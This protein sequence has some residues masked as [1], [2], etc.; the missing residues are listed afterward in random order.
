MTRHE[1]TTSADVP[2]ARW[3]AMGADMRALLAVV[4]AG[5]ATVAGP[6][7]T[8]AP[9]IDAERLAFTVV[10]PGSGPVTVD[11]HRAAGTGE[12]RTTAAT[13]GGMVIAALERARQNF[14][15][16]FTYT[17]D[18]DTATRGAAARIAADLYAPADRAVAGMAAPSPAAAVR[19]V[20]AHTLAEVT[21]PDG[22]A[23]DKDLETLLAT[24]IAELSAYRA[25]W[26]A[27]GALVRTPRVAATP[28]R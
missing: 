17:S 14:A 25:G 24:V 8:G 5:G 22:P 28:T 6:D 27:A 19:D 7:G 11:F 20:V 3:A 16:L 26:V 21:A 10:A 1:W 13:T 4:A 2:P 9:V 12:V 23:G 18:A 15:A